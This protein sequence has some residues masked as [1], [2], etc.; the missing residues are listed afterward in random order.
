MFSISFQEADVESILP[1]SGSAGK[2]TIED[3]RSEWI[4]SEPE[5]VFLGNA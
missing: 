4:E 1:H 5:N 2:D 3:G